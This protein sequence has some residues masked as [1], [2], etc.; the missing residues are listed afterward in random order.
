MAKKLY[1]EYESEVELEN[2]VK[3]VEE[4]V[5]EIHLPKE[6]KNDEDKKDKKWLNRIL[7]LILGFFIGIFSVWGSIAAV[8]CFV[9]FQPI[10][11][12]VGVLDTFTGG[13][14]SDIMFG[15]KDENGNIIKAGILD[16][17]YA[18]LKV[19]D[20]LGDSFSALKQLSSADGS[21]APLNEVSPKV[22]SAVDAIIKGL[23][24]Y[25]I[26]LD[27]EKLLNAPFKQGDDDTQSIGAYFKSS[28]LEAPAG[29]FFKAL[30][31]DMSPI[32]MALCYGVE[33]TD[34]VVGENGTI[35]MLGTSQK[36][37]L[38][39][40]LNDNMNAAF[41]DVLLC[42]ALDVK[43]DS[44][45]ILISIAYGND[46]TISGNEILCDNPRTI[47][48]LRTSKGAFMDD[49]PLTSVLTEERDNGVTMYMLYGKE[50]IHY[51]IDADNKIVMKQQRILVLQDA[52][53]EYKVYNEYAEPLT[54][55]QGTAGEE[56]FVAGYT[57]NFAARSYIDQTGHEYVLSNA[58]AQQ[59]TKDGLADVYYLLETDG[60]KA[61]YSAHNLGDLDGNDN[62]ITRINSRLTIGELMDKDDIDNNKFLKHVKNYTIK[63][64]PNA[65]EDL[66]INEVYADEI[67]DANGNVQGAWRYLICTY[68]NGNLVEQEYTLN[69]LDPLIDN[70]KENIHQ[71]T[72]FKL[73]QDGLIGFSEE[74]LNHGIKTEVYS[75]D[76]DM[77]VPINLS[78]LNGKTKI[79]ELTLDQMIE[80]TDTLVQL[81]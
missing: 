73:A 4:E 43:A 21:L 37:T 67:Y 14:V 29:E 57:L 72:L 75:P 32:I 48:E 12:T 44:N 71:T 45:K 5:S 41:D 19:K 70:M 47:G 16:E 63:E 10:D 20:L 2:E 51:G 55:Q 40:L 17:K 50:N 33:G 22:G 6:K 77:V 18:E 46:Y 76:A 42:D 25:G 64:L 7:C 8:T 59:E 3:E 49:V 66:S 38:G 80:Y 23:E 74:T 11:N 62:L 27:R 9:L 52:N 35:T 31:S 56:D 58:R 28:L 68:Q 34:Y 79:G 26:P 61:F 69:H 1:D 54:A 39:Q 13:E 60:S 78:F 36:T 65:L 15:E 53:N 81:I 24:K 30:G